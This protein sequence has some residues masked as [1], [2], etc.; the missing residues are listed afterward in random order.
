MTDTV[1]AM[2]CML[3]FSPFVVSADGLLG[4]EAQKVLQHLAAKLADRNGKSYSMVCGFVR[5]RMS[6]AIVRATHVCLRGS[7]I[8]ASRMSN[9]PQWEACGG[10]ELFRY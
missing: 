6:I 1:G 5:A 2:K 10:L 4:K 8:P 7:R 3:R 9:R